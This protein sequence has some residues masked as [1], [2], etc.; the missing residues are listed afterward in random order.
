M[1]TMPL[2]RAACNSTVR[3]ELIDGVAIY[4]RR[5]WEGTGEGGR[6]L[7]VVIVGVVWS[8]WETVEITRK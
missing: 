3:S 7:L 2:T 1:M 4:W 8:G 6:K 5:L